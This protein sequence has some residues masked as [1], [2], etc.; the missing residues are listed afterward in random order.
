ME[1]LFETSPNV[2]RRSMCGLTKY[3]GRTDRDE[4]QI[5]LFTV[6]PRDAVHASVSR[7]LRHLEMKFQLLF[8][9]FQGQVFQPDNYFFVPPNLSLE[10]SVAT[11]AL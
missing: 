5:A 10:I 7:V 4:S 1:S 11:V 9:D 6:N 8:P 3:V 2:C